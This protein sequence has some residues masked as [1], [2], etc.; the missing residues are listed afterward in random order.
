MCEHH[1]AI[2]HNINTDFSSA[3]PFQI[4]R[5]AP[6]VAAV[7]GPPKRTASAL[8]T[9]LADRIAPRRLDFDH[10]GAKIRQQPRAERCS[11]KMTDL[12]HAK[13]IENLLHTRPSSAVLRFTFVHEIGFVATGRPAPLPPPPPRGHRKSVGEG[14]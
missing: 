10:V 5:D 9:P 1:G 6:L 13:T 11:D 4:H 12:E 14:R 7:H 3:Y 8:N 2:L